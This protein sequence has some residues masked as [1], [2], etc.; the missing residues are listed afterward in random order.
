MNKLQGFY[1]LQKLGLLT[2]PWRKFEDE[3]ELDDK[4]LWT[5]RTAVYQGKDFDLPR[6][7]GV[8]SAAAKQKYREYKRRLAA[9][10]LIIY[11]PYF[12][13][14]KSGVIQIREKEMIIEACKQDL[15]NLVTYGH[16]D[17]TYFFDNGSVTSQGKSDFL[18]AAEIEE[19]SGIKSLIRNRFCSPLSAGMSVMLEWSYAYHS[20]IHKEPVGERYLVFYECRVTY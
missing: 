14:E 6:A 2:V 13:A 1:E 10:D 7:V 15:W 20:N 4:V 17:V 11:Y 12:A 3:T 9:E 16:K 18:S 5:V 19:L 8:T